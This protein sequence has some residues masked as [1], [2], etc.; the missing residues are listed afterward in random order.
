MVARPVAQSITLT[1]STGAF[2]PIYLGVPHRFAQ[3]SFL[4]ASTKSVKGAL[5]GSIGDAATWASVIT[6]TTQNSTGTVNLLST[7]GL[8]FDKLRLNVT[9]NELTSTSANFKAWLAAY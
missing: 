4:N 3:F 9:D 6:L 1:T 2:G 5:Q 7:G 8:V